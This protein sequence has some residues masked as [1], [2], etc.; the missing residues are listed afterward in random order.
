MRLAMSCASS[1]AVVV[2][3]GLGTV[4]LEGFVEVWEER[5]VMGF[6]S[7]MRPMRRTISG[8]EMVWMSDYIDNEEVGEDVRSMAKEAKLI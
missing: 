2:E 8:Q 5:A 7:R 4:G 1:L 3:F 6:W